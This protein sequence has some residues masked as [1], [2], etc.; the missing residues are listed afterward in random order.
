MGL[1][2]YEDADGDEQSNQIIA[3]G[4]HICCSKLERG[5]TPLDGAGGQGYVR[6]QL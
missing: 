5:W 3:L 6:G 4:S 2:Q 1:G